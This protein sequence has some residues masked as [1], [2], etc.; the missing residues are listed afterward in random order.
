[1]KFT[2]KHAFVIVFVGVL[3]GAPLSAVASPTNTLAQDGPDINSLLES[4][5]TNGAEVMLANIDDQGVPGVIY[6][7]LGI[8]SSA[9]AF[10]NEMYDGCIAMALISTHGEFLEMILDLLAGGDLFGGD[11]GGGGFALA[12]DGGFDPNQILEMLGTEFSLLITVFINVPETDSLSRMT[13][14]QNHLTSQFGFSFLDILNLRIDQSLFEGSDI[15]LPFDSIDLYIRQETHDFTS[16]VN[17][18]FSVMN[19]GGFL[20]GIDKTKITNAPAS[21]GGLL[22]I[23]DMADIVELINTFGGNTT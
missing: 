1:M 4:L 9:L 19:Q 10:D 23:P 6:G 11:G 7:Q 5:L 21:A 3:I 17:S 22:A 18:M 8:P 2:I 16:A 14:I 12:Q 20:A 13:S 15:T